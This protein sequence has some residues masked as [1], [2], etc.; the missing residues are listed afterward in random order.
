MSDFVSDLQ[1]C[2][3]IDDDAHP[4]TTGG[5]KGR[6][7]RD[8]SLEPFGS[9]S[10]AAPF[11]GPTIPRSE[12]DER[13]RDLEKAQAR[14]S[15][16]CEAMGVKIKDQK[17]TNYCWVFATT[18]CAEIIRAVQGQDHVDLSPS[19]VGAK[20]KN[21]RNEGGWG[22]E[23]LRYGVEHGWVPSSMWPDTAL[24]R[25]YDTPQAEASRAKY[26]VDEWWEL[27]PGN[28]EQL[29]TCLLGGFPVS[30]G[31]SWWGHQVCASDLVKL[32]GAGNYGVR[33]RNSWGTVWSQNGQAILTERKAT[34]DDAVS[35]RSVTAS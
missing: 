4:D 33:I 22:T 27:Q 19:S 24:D 35:P 2:P 9:L 20:I 8:W 21:F 3:V 18:T 29:A 15:D 17:S 12:W 25:R 30:I 31:L 13:I 28:F 10:F 14:I 1:G 6:M 26:Q 11:S 23:S 7:P 34:P 16:I 5:M 32:D